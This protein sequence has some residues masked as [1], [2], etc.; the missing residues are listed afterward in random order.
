MKIFLSSLDFHIADKE[1]KIY[2]TSK[3]VTVYISVCMGDK[4][5]IELYDFIQDYSNNLTLEEFLIDIKENIPR[6]YAINIIFIPHVLNENNIK[7]DLCLYIQETE[8]AEVTTICC[9]N[10]P[11]NK[12]DF[13]NASVL[14]KSKCFLIETIFNIQL[15]KESSYFEL[16]KTSLKSY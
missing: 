5:F 6:F 14:Y 4:I 2:I 10:I 9:G 16:K 13:F 3:N 7:L 8:K 12:V 11:I 1:K 15:K